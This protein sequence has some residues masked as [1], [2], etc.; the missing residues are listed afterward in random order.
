[1]KLGDAG[2]IVASDHLFIFYLSTGETV[3]EK[4]SGNVDRNTTIIPKAETV[5]RSI[6]WIEI[7][8]LSWFRSLVNESEF[9]HRNRYDFGVYFRWCFIFYLSFQDIQ[10]FLL[11]K[12]ILELLVRN[13]YVENL[14]KKRPRIQ[15]IRTL[16]FCTVTMIFE[17]SIQ[18]KSRRSSTISLSIIFQ[19][20]F[21]IIYFKYIQTIKVVL[22]LHTITMIFET[23]VPDKSQRSSTINLPTIF[24]DKSQQS[25]TINLPPISRKP[26]SMIIHATWNSIVQ[27]QLVYHR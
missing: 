15:W 23:F 3:R 26:L 20:L 21:H 11:C 5:H 7:I 9:Y 24:H 8:I 2:S 17:T 25:S 14:H 4:R 27:C 22:I 16:F 12:K 13:L 19:S 18:H 1:M 6:V 10:I